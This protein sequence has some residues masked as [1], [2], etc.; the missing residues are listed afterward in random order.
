MTHEPIEHN[1]HGLLI[2]DKPGGITSRAALDRAMACFPRGTRMGHTG[3]LDPLA[4]GVLVLCVGNA[5]RLAEY[6]QRMRKIYHCVMRLGVRSNTDDSDG[7]VENVAHVEQPGID[8]IGE[9]LAGFI[10]TIEQVPPGFSA[11]KV[12]GKRA[13]ALARSGKNVAL[14]PRPVEI[15]GIELLNYSY[16][17]LEVEVRCGKGTY[18]RSLARDLGEKLGCGAIV[19]TLRRMSVGPFRAEQAAALDSDLQTMRSMLLPG[20]A[21]LS[22]LPRVVLDQESLRRLGCG[23]T[24]PLAVDLADDGEVAV[25]DD[26]SRLMAVGRADVAQRLLTP[27]KVFFRP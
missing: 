21:A 10:G 3:T 26:A 24:I 18:I 23:Q 20:E 25:F 16:P 15:Y 14:A 7:L 2:I 27:E 9:A 17:L 13:Y 8:G 19:E 4:T 6:V 11:A 5:T 22:D 1:L 12:S